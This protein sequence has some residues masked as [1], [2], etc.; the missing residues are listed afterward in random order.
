MHL[1]LILPLDEDADAKD[2]FPDTGALLGRPYA[3]GSYDE[4]VRIKATHVKVYRVN[5]TT[6][7]STHVGDHDFNAH[8]C[9]TRWWDILDFNKQV[10]RSTCSEQLCRKKLHRCFD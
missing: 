8:Y 5:Q 10:S 7:D 2:T 6:G 9:H 1:S 4:C 3:L